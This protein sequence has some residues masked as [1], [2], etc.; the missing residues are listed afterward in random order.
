MRMTRRPPTPLEETCE[1]IDADKCHV[2][3]SRNIG[4][5]DRRLDAH[6]EADI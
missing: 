6:V 1:K 4:T 3:S 2:P 5:L